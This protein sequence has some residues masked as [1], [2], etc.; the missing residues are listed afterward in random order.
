MYVGGNHFL[1]VRCI[2]AIVAKLRSGA[3]M[4]ML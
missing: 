1:S 3:R 2:E 4:N